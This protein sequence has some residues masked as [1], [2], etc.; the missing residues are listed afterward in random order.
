M[1]GEVTRNSIGPLTGRA[2]PMLAWPSRSS[3]CTASCLLL[4]PKR[5][6]RMAP[7]LASVS[8]ERVT[9][10]LSNRLRKALDE[11]SVGIVLPSGT[12][13]VPVTPVGV[14]A[15]GAQTSTVPMIASKVASWPTVALTTY[16][17]TVRGMPM[18]SAQLTQ[19]AAGRTSQAPLP[20]SLRI[21]SA[22]RSDQIRPSPPATGRLLPPP[23]LRGALASTAAGAFPGHL[24]SL[25]RQPPRCRQ[26]GC[27][28]NLPDPGPWLPCAQNPGR[29][30]PAP[31]PG[32]W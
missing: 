31:S 24:Q 18:S 10:L 26:V 3:N 6:E 12:L 2:T 23:G 16:Q 8:K 15:P 29:K 19:N 9:V 28:R 11:E 4:R 14:V 20:G 5:G 27:A 17:R 30:R 1:W 21:N 32:Q 7:N 13:A 22:P 25:R